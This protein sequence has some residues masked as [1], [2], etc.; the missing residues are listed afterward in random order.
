MKGKYEG[1]ELEH[2]NLLEECNLAKA[3]LLEYEKT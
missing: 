2:K 1:F 3:K